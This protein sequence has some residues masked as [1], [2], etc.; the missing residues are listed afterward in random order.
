MPRLTR[1]RAWAI[2]LVATFTMAISYV[3]RQTLSV[4]APTVTAKLNIGEEAYGWLAAAFSLAY[5][6]GAP[7]AGRAIDKVGARRGLLFAVLVWSVVAA[8]HALVPGFL[9]LFALR[10]ALGFAEAPSFPGAAQTIHR[11]LPPADRAR[12][13]GVLFTGSSIGAMIAAPLSTVLEARFGFRG[14]FVGVA[15]LGGLVWIPLWLFV[16]SGADARAVLDR[17]EQE[18]KEPAPPIAEVLLHPAVLRGIVLVLAS[19]PVMAF[20]L[21]WGAKFLV[22]QHHLVQKDVGRYLWMP[23]LLYDLG[24]VAFGDLAA[25]RKSS[26]S[27]RA[28]LFV[29]MLLTCSIGALG[30]PRTP[31]GTTLLCGVAMAGG[32]GLFAILTADMLARVPPSAVSLAGGLT[33][34]AQSLAYIVANPLIG[35]S[36]QRTH[37]FAWATMSLAAWLVPGCLLWLLWKAPPIVRSSPDSS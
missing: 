29:A 23:P 4:L 31:W 22:A 3:D 2:A 20:L 18:T 7:V 15:M 10:I 32:G 30:L 6:I 33:A 25:R 1:R 9:A 14:A 17:T 27:P 12:G 8:S 28:L 19:A 21:L 37:T 24:S 26:D 36:V 16:T 13:F 5:L 35:R 34:A 11:V